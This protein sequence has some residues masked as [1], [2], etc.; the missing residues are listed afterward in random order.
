MKVSAKNVTLK[1]GQQVTLR[2]ANPADAENMLRHLRTSHSESYQ[3]M[4]Q[5]VDFE[6]NEDQ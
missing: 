5:S 6:L 4:N 2:S 3:N 1:N